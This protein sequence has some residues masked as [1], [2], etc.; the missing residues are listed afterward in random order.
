VLVTGAAG[1]LGNAVARRLAGARDVE[2]VATD[3][4][5]ADI[6]GTVD[7]S[8]D[9]RDG[10]GDVLATHRIETIVHHAFVIQQ[11]RRPAVAHAVN[12]EATARLV[13]DARSAGVATIVYPSSTTTYGAW[14]GTGLHT[15]DEPL[16]PLPGFLYSAQK[17][18]VEAMLRDA[19]VGGGPDAAVLRACIVLAPGAVNFITASLSLPFMP[20]CAGVDPPMQF[21]HIDD[22]VG[23]VEAVLGCGRSGT[24]NVAGGGTVSW[25]ELIG[26]AG[27][28]PMPLPE[29]V[30]RRLVDVTWKLHLQGRS[31]S[32]GL[33]LSQHPWLASTERITR[34]LGW[35][36][37]YSSRQAVESWV[38]GLDGSSARRR[39]RRPAGERPPH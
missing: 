5:A 34:E 25:R 35:T 33:P 29:G 11:S 16:R 26:L 31:D 12:V 30:L 3:V 36:P 23:A 32:S 6:P 37:Q 20:V 18:E 2:V 17:A 19:R 10:L 21:L 24:W 28:R 9:I 15:E 38:A 4:V 13:E 39:R 1:F 7:V 22:Y 14:P 8:R 27:S